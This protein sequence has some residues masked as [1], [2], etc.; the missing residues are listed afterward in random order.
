MG[1]K[2]LLRL[3]IPG[4]EPVVLRYAVFDFNGTLAEGGRLLSGVRDRLRRL[5][6]CLDVVVI[7]ADTFGTAREALAGTGCRVIVLDKE[8]GGPAKESLVRE[9][10]AGETVAFGNGANDALMLKAARLGIAVVLAEGAAVTSISA[11][12][13]VVTGINDGIDLLLKPERLI[14]TLRW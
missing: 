7:T 2:Q 10:G 1:V 11:A 14:A 9:Y 13:V 4:K 6:A 3:D 12:D 8:P 5:G